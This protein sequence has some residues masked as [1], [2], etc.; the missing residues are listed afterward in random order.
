MHEWRNKGKLIYSRF[1]I[2][3]WN[4]PTNSCCTCQKHPTPKYTSTCFDSE[5]FS[6]RRTRVDISSTAYA[7]DGCDSGIQLMGS[8]PNV[9]TSGAINARLAMRVN[10]IKS[11]FK[12]SWSLKDMKID[13][14]RRLETFDRRARNALER[15]ANTST[16]QSRISCGKI[17]MSQKEWHW[18][19]YL[20]IPIPLLRKLLPLSLL[21]SRLL[22]FSYV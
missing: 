12:L 21:I 17:A 2:S 20:R 18:P 15:V 6:V 10:L 9:K 11:H 14:W 4:L 7:L 19:K 5:S 8:W 16:L 22:A 13:V 3:Y 1:S